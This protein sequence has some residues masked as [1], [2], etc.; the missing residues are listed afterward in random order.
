MSDN[1]FVSIFTPTYNRKDKLAKLFSS[2]CSQTSMN[3]EWLIVDDGSIDD[4]KAYIEGLP[5]QA[6]DIRYIRKENGGKHTAINIGVENALGEVFAIVDSDDYLIKDA[7]KMI[8]EWFNEISDCDK[9]GG[10]AGQR[11]HQDNTIIG[12]FPKTDFV[13]ALMIERDKYHINGDKF[14][15]YYTKVLKDYPFPVFEGERFL[16]E[17]VVWN[18]IAKKGLML[19][20]HHEAIYIGEYLENGLSD[21]KDRLVK[22]SPLGYALYIRELA[23]INTSLKR[24]L[25]YYSYYY[26]IRKD[27]KSIDEICKEIDCGKT[28][29][30]IAVLLRSMLKIVRR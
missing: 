12:N 1:I 11:A 14:E 29:L 26:D 21:Q 13:D 15:I 17:A 8:V 22:Q 20:W 4:T 5:K 23:L 30:R 2:L 7:V 16:T 28:K 27:E 3:F 10:V 25:G 18:R 19:R 6:F 24:M 9:F